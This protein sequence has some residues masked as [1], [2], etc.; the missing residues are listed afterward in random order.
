MSPRSTQNMN[1]CPVLHT[2]PWDEACRHAGTTMPKR[3]GC[4]SRCT[5]CRMRP[6]HPRART[7]FRPGMTSLSPE[8]A[9]SQ[10]RA[11]ILGTESRF[12]D[13]D[14]RSRTADAGCSSFVGRI[15]V[16]LDWRLQCLYVRDDNALADMGRP[17]HRRH[18]H[19]RRKAE[20]SPTC[21]PR[22]RRLPNAVV[23][24]SVVETAGAWAWHRQAGASTSW[25]P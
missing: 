9:A 24:G 18:R 4:M 13:R 23:D 6:R 12:V 14:E 22:D 19:S 7:G 2:R 11:A 15:V 21:G 5:S 10:R 16:A 20:E 1:A 3:A 8:F 17:P 25:A